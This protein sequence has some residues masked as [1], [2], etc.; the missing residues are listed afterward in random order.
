[1]NC[2]DYFH[3][4]ALCT[5]IFFMLLCVGFV[6]NAYCDSKASQY[7][8]FFISVLACAAYNLIDELTHRA[9]I[10][11]WWEVVGAVLTFAYNFSNRDGY[12]DYLFQ[13]TKNRWRS[14]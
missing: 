6:L 13:N 3:N 12:L 14:A 10:I 2:I 4:D 1:M 11:D 9:N 8:W 7:R 5:R